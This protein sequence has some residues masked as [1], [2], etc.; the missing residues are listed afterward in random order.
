MPTVRRSVLVPH[1]CAMMFALVED[2]ERYPQF[3]PWCSGAHVF[4]RSDELTRAR[5]DIDYHG[6]RTHIATLNRKEPPG[7]ITLELV[8]GPFDHF[9]GDWHFTPLGEAGCRV[10]LALDYT[11][12]H[13][14]I[15]AVLKPVF[16][17]I[18]ETLVDRFVER[19]ERTAQA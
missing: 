11:F 10:E 1:P 4:E 16:G 5:L 12:K 19:A 6:L 15:E 8:E 13:R 18:A 9:K 3:L 17:H 7:H 14:T 2:C